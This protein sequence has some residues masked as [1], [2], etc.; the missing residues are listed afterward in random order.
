MGGSCALAMLVQSTQHDMVR[1]LMARLALHAAATIILP[2]L[3]YY[4][5]LAPFTLHGIKTHLQCLQRAV[6]G[7]HLASWRRGTNRT[8][9]RQ[10]AAAD[11]LSMG[12]TI[13]EAPSSLDFA[14]YCREPTMPE[15]MADL[16]CE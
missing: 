5:A 3:L 15:G 12:W 11:Q 8:S 1:I 16:P 7:V 6:C 2:R 4:H 14:D 13:L 10:P 9:I